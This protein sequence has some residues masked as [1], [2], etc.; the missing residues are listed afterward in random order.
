M[1]AT[2]HQARGG[3]GRGTAKLC[4][5]SLARPFHSVPLSSQSE[6]VRW[7]SLAWSF[8]SIPRSSQSETKSC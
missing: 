6:T 8:R 4:W 3:K 1:D 7:L 2:H 5:L